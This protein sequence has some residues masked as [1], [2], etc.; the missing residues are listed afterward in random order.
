[1]LLLIIDSSGRGNDE[2]SSRP[3]RSTPTGFCPSCCPSHISFLKLLSRATADMQLSRPSGPIWIRR[4]TTV[5]SLTSNLVQL[6]CVDLLASLRR[7]TKDEHLLKQAKDLIEEGFPQSTNFQPNSMLICTWKD[8]HSYLDRDN[9]V[10]ITLTL[11]SLRQSSCRPTHFKLRS[12]PMERKRIRCSCTPKCSSS[13]RT[14]R[15]N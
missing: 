12:S 5:L 4:F 6:T 3:C 11:N 10:R 9:K 7:Y 8:V 1:M 15:R 14:V 2:R 13:P